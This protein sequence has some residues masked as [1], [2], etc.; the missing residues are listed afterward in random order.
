MKGQSKMKQ[1]KVYY[2]SVVTRTKWRN[3]RWKE[4]KQFVV[5]YDGKTYANCD[6]R[7]TDKRLKKPFI[8][9][10]STRS[11]GLLKYRID[12]YFMGD[13]WLNETLTKILEG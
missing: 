12:N 11:K 13:K 3:Y 8:C 4:E 1:V 10:Y 2:R 6:A 9:I 7:P 5:E